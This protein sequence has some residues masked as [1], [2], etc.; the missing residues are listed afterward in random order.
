MSTATSTDMKTMIENRF[1]LK[2]YPEG[3]PHDIDPDSH[4]TV[5]DLF[6]ECVKK[7]ASLPAFVNMDKTITYKELDDM[8]RDFASYLQNVLGLQ[9]GDR[10]AIMMPNLLQ[11]PVVMFGAMRAGLIV[12]NTNPLYTPKEMQHQFNDSGAKAIVIVENFAFNLEKVIKNTPIEHVVTTAIGDLMGGLKK[13]LVNFVVKYV[14]KMT[15]AF[16]LPGAVKLNDALA[17]GA[18]QT[19]KRP[20][21]AITDVAFLQ[22]TG[23]T[24]GLSKGATLLHRN[25]MANMEQISAWV[26]ANFVEGKEVIV[27]ALPMYHIFALTANCLALFKVG[28]K[29]ILITNPRDMKSFMKDLKK[30]QM[31]VFTGV[32]TLFVGL[33]NQPDFDEVDYSKLKMSLGGGMAVQDVVAK[34]W[35]QRTGSPLIEAYGLSETS[36]ALTANPIDGR[37]Q[38]GTIGMPVPSTYIMIADDNGNPVGLG[39]RGEIWAKGPQ[40]MQG[41]WEKPEETANVFHDGWFKTGDIAIMQEDGFCKIVDR[42]KEMIIVSG[43][44]VFPNEVENVIVTNPK[45]LEVGVI[46][47]PDDKTTEAVKAFVVVKDPS[48]TV[49]ELKA[50]CKENMT[51]YKCPKHIEFKDELP[52]TNVGKILRRALKEEEEQKRKA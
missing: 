35:A 39:E 43:F 15:P 2:N 27:T 18:R 33:M 29:N 47:V 26:G 24:T 21:I 16:S 50:F 7:Y 44:N 38:I 52:K 8:S 45:V 20:D 36:P 4:G 10:I 49:E 46:G 40:V 14:K 32:N 28:G 5:V 3:A 25:I 17:Q 19:Y 34:E 22:Y 23:G 37:H 41:Y 1:W 6:E 42:K 9:K 30:V 12:V 13:H 31:T 48:L 11:F 51:N